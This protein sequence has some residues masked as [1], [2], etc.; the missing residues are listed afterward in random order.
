MQNPPQ[1]KF[2]QCS[3]VF[4]KSGVLFEKLKTLTS[5]N[6]HELNIFFAEILHMFPAYHGLQKGDRDFFGLFRS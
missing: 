6:Y 4:K 3:I 2:R 5:S 1:K